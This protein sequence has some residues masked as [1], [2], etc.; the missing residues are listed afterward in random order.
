MRAARVQTKDLQAYVKN[1]RAEGISNSTIN[2]ELARL[3]RA[4]NLSRESTPPKVK[5]VPIF[6]RLE[7]PPPRKGFFEHDGICCVAIRTA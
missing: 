7:E 6:P 3:K 1:R 4:F 2:R 5:Q